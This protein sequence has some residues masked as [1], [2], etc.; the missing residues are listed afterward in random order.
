MAEPAVETKSNANAD[1][2]CAQCAKP[3]SDPLACGDCG[4]LI[5]RHCGMPLERVDELG[6]G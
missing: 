1:F 6:I 3:V 4:S 5:C 2:Y